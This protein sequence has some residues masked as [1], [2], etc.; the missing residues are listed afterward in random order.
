[1]DTPGVF[2]LEPELQLAWESRLEGRARA[3]RLE[4]CIVD[5]HLQKAILIKKVTTGL[6]TLNFPAQVISYMFEI[7]LKMASRL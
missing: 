3:C 5:K 7:D 4:S 6:R 2:F 1:M